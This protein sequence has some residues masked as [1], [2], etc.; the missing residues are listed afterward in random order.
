MILEDMS[1]L[2]MREVKPAYIDVLL[3][4]KFLRDEESLVTLEIMFDSYYSDI[5]FMTGSSGVTILNDLRDYVAN[6]RGDYVSRIEKKIKKFDK[7]IENI[8]EKYQEEIQ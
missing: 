4:G 7:L 1:Y 2:S 6:N 5:G 8:I 3:Q